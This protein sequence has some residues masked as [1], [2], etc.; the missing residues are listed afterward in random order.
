M[1]IDEKLVCR[2]FRDT[3]LTPELIYHQIRCDNDYIRGRGENWRG[4][5]RGRPEY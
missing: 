3:E 4:S 5:G 1:Y 2:L